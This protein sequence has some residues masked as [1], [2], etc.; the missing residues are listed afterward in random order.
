MIEEE[1]RQITRLNAEEE[2]EVRGDGESLFT[3]KAVRGVENEMEIF[4]ASRSQSGS[5]I[6]QD[7]LWRWA[8]Q[9]PH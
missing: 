5:S 2:E 6:G 4:V 7:S 1:R 9:G 3:N 8:S